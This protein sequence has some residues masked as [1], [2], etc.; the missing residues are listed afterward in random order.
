MQGGAHQLSFFGDDRHETVCVISTA[1]LLS[2]PHITDP[3]VAAAATEG[4]LASQHIPTDGSLQDQPGLSAI[5]GGEA[6]GVSNS[7]STSSNRVELGDASRL[8]V[9][10]TLRAVPR[11]PYG[12]VIS[13]VGSL[14][15][16]S[17]REVL[18][19]GS[20]FYVLVELS[21]QYYSIWE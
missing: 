16:D 2:L 4:L 15:E 18:A 10:R 3:I 1:W 9:T 8:G 19:S 5:L 20:R 21:R 14:S 7:D 13:D 6:V 17:A 11:R 12:T